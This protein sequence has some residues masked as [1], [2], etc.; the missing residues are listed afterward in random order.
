[1][2][3]VIATDTHERAM[4]AVIRCLGAV[5]ADVTA[6]ASSR[7]APGMWSSAVA[8]RR[9]VADPNV[10]VAAFIDDLVRIVREH[11]HDVLLPGTDA[12]LLALSRNREQLEPYV[13]LA[14]P[15]ADAVE[16]A[17]NRTEVSRAARTVGLDPP[18]EQL[19]EGAAEALRTAESF[20]CTV[21]VKPVEVVIERDGATHR[22]GAV[23]VRGER[24]LERESD[25]VRPCIVQRLATGDVVSFCG[26]AG[27]GGL[28]GYAMVR[29]ERLWPVE[30]G[31]ACFARTIEVPAGLAA[32]VQAFTAELGWEGIFQLELIEDESGE[33][34]TIDFNPRPYGSLG[35]AVEAG[36]PLPQIWV[37]AQLG[38]P[39]DRAVGRPGVRYRWEDADLRN[40]FSQLRNGDHGGA[41]S[42]VLPRPGVSHAYLSMRDPLPA[43]VRIGELLRRAGEKARYH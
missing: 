2:T 37:D 36:A 40:V 19:C 12:S 34:R 5:G 23:L 41:L 25:A 31:N 13:R 24:R 10:S 6:T 22:A 27:E 9:R 29:Y 43:V 32:K 28:L 39:T 7:V 30:A 33:L 35:L 8:A 1:M 15:A 4:L 38:R 26:V 20:G 3:R 11:P 42:A 21:M 16:R 14:M 18:E 17:L